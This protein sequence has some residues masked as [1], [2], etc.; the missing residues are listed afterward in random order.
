MMLVTIL[1]RL[2]LI[3]VSHCCCAGSIFVC[4]SIGLK[5]ETLVLLYFSVNM[6]QYLTPGDISKTLLIFNQHLDL[7]SSD[8]MCAEVCQIVCQYPS[9]PV[10]SGFYISVKLMTGERKRYIHVLFWKKR[11][12]AVY[13]SRMDLLPHF[14]GSFFADT[15]G[16]KS[17]DFNSSSVKKL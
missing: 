1:M 4:K 16:N 13:S 3:T 8:N 6:H 15:D 17:Q 10:S 12:G 9:L 11:L 7:C 14:K 2:M 5:Q